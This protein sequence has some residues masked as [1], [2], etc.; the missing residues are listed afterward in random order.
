LKQKP[1]AMIALRKLL[2]GY[3]PCTGHIPERV[4]SAPLRTVNLEQA[5]E[6][7]ALAGNLKI[8]RG[9]DD[10]IGTLPMRHGSK[11]ART[12]SI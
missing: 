6:I 1:T 8:W 2:P 12:A 3:R 9:I 11:L 4:A 5:I 7:Q 10:K